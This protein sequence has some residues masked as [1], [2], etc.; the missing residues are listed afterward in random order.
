MNNK[1]MAYIC[2]A[3]DFAFVIFDIYWFIF[4]NNPLSIVAA[5]LCFAGGIIILSSN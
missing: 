1:N 5:I 2:A 3:I 4:H